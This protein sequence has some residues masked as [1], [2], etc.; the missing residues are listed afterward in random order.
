MH[1]HDFAKK[2]I[3]GREV[4]GGQV[5]EKKTEPRKGSATNG[6]TPE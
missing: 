3:S 6:N 1:L 4:M 5:S 2:L